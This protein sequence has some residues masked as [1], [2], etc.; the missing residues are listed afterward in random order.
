MTDE[1]YADRWVRRL[2]D[3]VPDAVGILLRG[4]RVRGDAGPHSDVDFDILVSEGRR[5]ERPS[6]F[7]GDVCVDLDPRGRRVARHPAGAA[8]LGVRVALR[9]PTAL[10]LGGRRRVACTP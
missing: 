5:D 8:A 7:D 9:R 2:R 6:W 4:S 3:E 10:V 1:D